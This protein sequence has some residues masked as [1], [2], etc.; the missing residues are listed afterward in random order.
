MTHFNNTTN[1]AKTYSKI[2]LEAIKCLLSTAFLYGL[3]NISCNNCG[4]KLIAYKEQEPYDSIEEE[5]IT[6][7]N[8]IV[9]NDYERISWILLLFNPELKCEFEI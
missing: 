6:L 3:L 5:L 8:K 4:P 9:K 2:N 1:E 7:Q